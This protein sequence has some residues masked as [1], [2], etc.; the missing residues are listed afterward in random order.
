MRANMSPH[1]SSQGQGTGFWDHAEP[2]TRNNSS[3]WSFPRARPLRGGVAAPEETVSYRERFVAHDR[4]PET[5]AHPKMPGAGHMHLRQLPYA[6]IAT[7]AWSITASQG[8]HPL[9]SYPEEFTALGYQMS[10][11][12]THDPFFPLPVYPPEEVGKQH[13]ICRSFSYAG[14]SPESPFP[15]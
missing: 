6:V 14:V 5:R 7:L 12:G 9:F 3:L 15:S 1:V 13:L 4:C 2:W 10:G 8:R 11:T